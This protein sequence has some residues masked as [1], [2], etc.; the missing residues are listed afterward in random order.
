MDTSKVVIMRRNFN[1]VVFKNYFKWAFT[2]K[3]SHFT[4][5]REAIFRNI[6]EKIFHYHKI[7][8]IHKSNLPFWLKLLHL[9]K[10]QLVVSTS[11]PEQRT[12]LTNLRKWCLN[13][14]SRKLLKP[15]Q[16]M[17]IKINLSVLRKFKTILQFS[18]FNVIDI[19]TR[20]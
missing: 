10:Q 13:L 18:W 1:K 2:E 16:G 5:F 15:T 14:L 12:V 11:F 4:F 9:R 3:L 20:R 6:N 19:R 17:E 7:S 8:L